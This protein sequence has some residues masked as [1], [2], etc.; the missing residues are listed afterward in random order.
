MVFY[1][2]ETRYVNRGMFIHPSA[3]QSL[4]YFFFN[5]KHSGS[6]IPDSYFEYQAGGQLRI[7]QAYASPGTFLRLTEIPGGRAANF[8]IDE[9]ILDGE[10]VLASNQRVLE[11]NDSGAGDVRVRIGGAIHKDALGRQQI[12]ERQFGLTGQGTTTDFTSTRARDIQLNC[13]DGGIENESYP[14][15][16]S[17]NWELPL[18]PA[19]VAT[20]V[21]LNETALWLEAPMITDA[22]PANGWPQGVDATSG[23]N[24]V[25]TVPDQSGLS[26]DVT[27]ATAGTKP[28]LNRGNINHRP[29]LAMYQ[30]DTSTS[31]R[32]LTNTSPSALDDA[33][34]DIT[35]LVVIVPSSSFAGNDS[36]LVACAGGDGTGSTTG[37]ALGVDAA[38][39]PLFRV[40]GDTALLSDV[41]ID[42]A[43]EWYRYLLIGR[44]NAT[45]G[46]ITVTCNGV[47]SDPVVG[48]TGTLT[49]HT[50]PLM[51][52]AAWNG[53]AATKG[54]EGFLGP[55]HVDLRELFAV[56]GFD[57]ATVATAPSQTIFTLSS[58]YNVPTSDD[59]LNGKDIRFFDASNG[60]APGSKCL[61]ED[62]V[63]S[64]RQVTLDTT[65]LP[66]G[67]STSPG[68]TVV[69]GDGVQVAYPEG[70][71][72]DSGDGEGTK[73]LNYLRSG[74]GVW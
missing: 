63:G 12:I 5:L 37:W 54:F 17:A 39:H 60:N 26:N 67:Y 3:E 57:D 33:V 10:P 19:R 18:N 20:V 41:T 53:S 74:W 69:V 31:Q 13:I 8:V 43:K 59:A 65:D 16:P 72:A 42:D 61:I 62:Y 28:V 51:V 25:Q 45:T 1:Q 35:V 6:P 40:Q 47:T 49:V 27:Q 4:E 24:R 15:R 71:L 55:V 2:F 32:W 66:A 46:E 23:E 44:R 70:P 56:N 14:I 29:C 64:T 38:G 48:D 7:L 21:P 58:A 68:F 73:R 52:G 36:I 50:R 34:G 30:K 9:L 22:T 11:I